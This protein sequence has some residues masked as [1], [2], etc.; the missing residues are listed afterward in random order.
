MHR[1]WVGWLGLCLSALGWAQTPPPDPLAEGPRAVKPSVGS[2]KAHVPRFERMYPLPGLT[3]VMM[4]AEL[5]SQGIAVPFAR[6]QRLQARILWVD[7]TANIVRYN[8][9]EKIQDLIAHV[10]DAGF[11]TVVFDVKPISGQVVYP[12]K[13][14]P[15]LAEWRGV[16]LPQ[17]LDPLKEMLVEAKKVGLTF[18]ISLNS[19]SEGHRMFHV[20]PGYDMPDQ[21]TVLYEPNPVLQLSSGRYPIAPTTNVQPQGDA[22]GAFTDASKI[23]PPAPGQFAITITKAGFV[24]DGFEQGGVGERVPVVPPGGCVLWGKG[25][26]AEWLKSHTSPGDP[27]TFDSPPLFVP[28][29]DRPEQQIPLMMNPN[30][31]RVQN[32]ALAILKEVVGN[33]AVDGVIYDDRLRFAGHNA[34]FREL[35]MR[36]F[37][38]YMGKTLDWPNDVYRYRYTFDMTQGITPGPYYQE[39]LNWRA[40]TMQEF[41]RRARAA[42]LGTRPGCQFGLYAGSW[43]GEYA[44]FG[45]NY[46]SPDLEAGFWYLTPEYR[47]AGFAPLLDFLITG[48]YYRQPTIYAAMQVGE[49]IG[50]TVEYAGYLSAQVARDMTWTYAGIALNLF[51]GDPDGLKLAL[52]A[53]CGSTAGVMVFDLSH[54]I[55]PMWPV[56]KEAFAQ[57]AK[58][59]HA[60]RKALSDARK[61]RAIFDRE[62][63]KQRPVV[64]SPGRP[65]AGH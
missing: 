20:G 45:S 27:V 51:K 56:F 3:G 35:S 29:R 6:A 13:I 17:E 44:S 36:Q 40:A 24:L 26:A 30:D 7:C 41:V 9:K 54:D 38:A 65:G 57:P 43:F 52:Q 47:S 5:L 15:R 58:P 23:P 31:P 12:S 60:D 11:N 49:P 46:G 64:I 53:A 25:Q 8:T 59:P 2:L 28:I 50:A 48:C 61:R 22:I 33:Y 10:R 37:E 63:V 39:W 16:A 4:D 14:A 1:A 18:F 32:R 55:E 21:Q 34:D 62:K 42:V 19:F